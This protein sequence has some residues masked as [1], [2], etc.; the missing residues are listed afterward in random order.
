[1]SSLLVVVKSHLFLALV[2]SLS[3]EAGE[4]QGGG[5][6]YQCALGREARLQLSS[7]QAGMCTRERSEAAAVTRT[8]LL[9]APG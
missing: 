7:R 9:E 5:S 1:M 2:H 4:R 3:S 8:H 6:H